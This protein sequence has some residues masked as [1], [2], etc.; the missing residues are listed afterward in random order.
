VT[1]CLIAFAL[2]LSA[3][4][5]RA[6]PLAARQR[7][8]QYAVKA[9]FIYNFLSFIEW[10]AAALSRPDA[11]FRL[12]IAGPDPFGGVLDATVRGESVSGH[13]IVV[14]RLKDD[15]AAA[16]CHVVFVGG[17]DEAR[18]AGVIRATERRPIL[19]IGEARRLLDLCG[20]IALVIDGDRV[21]FDINLPSLQ[22][23]GLRASA[24]LLRVARE[25]SDHFDRC[26]HF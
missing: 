6:A 11:P 18:M 16:V 3:S 1:R 17:V 25:A 4:V 15:Q 7:D 21:R 14:E 24:R 22:R 9:S 20:N 26:E 10:P 8:L 2:C 23:Q 19:V 12:C 5:V 13:P